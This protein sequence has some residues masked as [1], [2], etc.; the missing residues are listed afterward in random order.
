MIRADATHER[1]NPAMNQRST[2]TWIVAAAA[3]AA[4]AVGCKAGLATQGGTGGAGGN[5]DGGLADRRV[6]RD[7]A[8]SDVPPGGGDDAVCSAQ[9]VSAQPVPLDLYLMMD[10]SRSMAEDST[11][12]GL[13]K[14]EAVKMAMKA[15]F[16]DPQSAGIDV[17]LKYFPDE[18][19]GV[20]TTCQADSACGGTA[21]CQRRQSC[22]STGTTTSSVTQASLCT[23]TAP[24]A[25]TS[26][27]CALIQTCNTANTVYCV[28]GG[29]ACPAA[30]MPFDGYCDNRDICDP[31]DYAVPTVPSAVLPDAATALG[32]SLDQHTPDGYTPTGPALSGAVMY[33]QQRQTSNPGH[34]VAVVLV[35][36]GL[37]GGYIPGYPPQGCTPSDIPG[38]AAIATAGFGGTPS[39][40]TFVIGVFE[41]SEAATAT[42]NLNTLAAAGGTKTAVVIDT[43]TDVNAALQAALNQ[44]RTTAITCQFS[45]PSSSGSQFVDPSHV[46]VTFTS[47]ANVTT[48]LLRTKDGFNCDASNTGWRYDVDPTK[49]QPS[50]ILLCDQTCADLQGDPNGQIN[51][52]L[53]CLTMIVP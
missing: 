41:S 5:T 9:S 10:T 43:A 20:P 16:T 48:S 26:Q 17:G 53:G 51:I 31:A 4:A 23:P 47:G 29:P 50:Q 46:N 34:K 27:T 39:I 11:S 49:A 18:R 30:C 33:A 12:S 24:C 44:I 42:T 35:T 52:Q 2:F 7:T 15:F 28:S 36:D 25:S 6:P 37:P 13:T 45:I 38:V 19:A 22:V 21:T 40:P 8:S 1:R 3:L 14:W 32:T